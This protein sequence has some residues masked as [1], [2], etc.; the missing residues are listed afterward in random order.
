[1]S[2]KASDWNSFLFVERGVNDGKWKGRIY[3]TGVR[4]KN[5]EENAQTKERECK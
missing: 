2:H 4:E 1:M 5:A 3:C